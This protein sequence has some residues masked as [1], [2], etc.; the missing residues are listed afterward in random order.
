MATTGPSWSK[1]S[2][3][4][5]L[6]LPRQAGLNLYN[7]VVSLHLE[8]L[9]SMWRFKF[10]WLEGFWKLLALEVILIRKLIVN[11]VWVLW[12]PG[13]I[14]TPSATA[15]EL[16][17]FAAAWHSHGPGWFAA[18]LVMCGENL[19]KTLFDHVWS[20]QRKHTHQECMTCTSICLLHRVKRSFDISW[21][22]TSDTAIAFPFCHTW[23]L[24]WLLLVE[25][26]KAQ[27][28]WVADKIEQSS[29]KLHWTLKQL[30]KPA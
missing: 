3:Y 27:F 19:G 10:L 30:M 11:D 1:E 12:M 26:S 9:C 16:Y 8:Y 28:I 24:T 22:W 2:L 20:L 7:N 21:K 14:A 25:A 4:L 17:R 29:K 18:A 6:C 5:D 23:F 13:A 15:A